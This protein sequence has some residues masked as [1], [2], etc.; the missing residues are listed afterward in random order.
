MNNLSDIVKPKWC[1]AKFW[2]SAKFIYEV[3][4]T[5]YI[6]TTLKCVLKKGSSILELGSG[7]CSPVTRLVK[8]LNLS[9]AVDRYK[10]S[11]LE[12]KK[13]K[14]FE[15]YVLADVR[16]PPF[17]SNSFDSV[18]ALD[19]IEH[20]SKS[21]GLRLMK[22]MES[23]SREK[24]VILTPNGY[25]S[26][27]Q[28]EDSNILQHHRSAWISVDFLNLGFAVFGING[29]RALR[30]EL[31][32]ATIKPQVIG[33]LVSKMTDRLVYNHPNS[34]FQLLCIKDKLE[35]GVHH[36]PSPVRQ[37]LSFRISSSNCNPRNEPPTFI[38]E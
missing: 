26:K 12:N 23:I 7:K 35:F 6:Q 19:V 30:G 24:V 25:S 38:R 21:E 13:R 20:L 27:E 22:Q 32:H 5:D 31:A 15:N 28:L 3:A 36:F 9:V 29:A 18:I 34:A 14:Y 4:F 37:K 16:Y 10:P 11:L 33:H 8:R 2:F 1:P 17:K